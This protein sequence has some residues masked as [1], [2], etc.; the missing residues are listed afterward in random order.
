MSS[1]PA[2]TFARNF[3]ARTQREL[4]IAPGAPWLIAPDVLEHYLADAFNQGSLSALQQ[5]DSAA[6]IFFGPVLVPPPPQL[7]ESTRRPR[8]TAGDTLPPTTKL[9]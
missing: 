7:P 4:R 6:G 3:V 8:L 1:Y 2:T 5:V 9:Q